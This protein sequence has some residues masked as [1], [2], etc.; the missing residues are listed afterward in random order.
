MTK[1]WTI[2][3]IA[4][5][6]LTSVLLYPLFLYL[7]NSN[8]FFAYYKTVFDTFFSSFRIYVI[9]ILFVGIS[10]VL[11]YGILTMDNEIDTSLERLYLEILDKNRE[12]EAGLFE[13]I[14]H[15]FKKRELLNVIMSKKRKKEGA[16]VNDFER[17]RMYLENELGPEPMYNTTQGNTILG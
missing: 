9:A 5:M 10:V 12:N 3:N 7:S 6:L 14:V 15:D 1:R 17:E 4:A 16:P 11:D 13:A 8:V 2:F